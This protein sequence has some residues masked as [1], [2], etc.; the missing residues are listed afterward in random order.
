[1]SNIKEKIQEIIESCCVSTKFSNSRTIYTTDALEKALY[2]LSSNNIP[3]SY[4]RENIDSFKDITDI[5]TLRWVEDSKEPYLC[6][7]EYG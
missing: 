4:T 5:I 2:F 3:H 7:F 6:W 1:M